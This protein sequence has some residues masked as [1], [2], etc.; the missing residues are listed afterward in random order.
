[1]V[2]PAGSSVIAP[3]ASEASLSD[4]G[5]QL[6]PPFVEC[7]TPPPAAPNQMSSGLTGLTAMAEALPLTRSPEKNPVM[8]A[9]PIGNQLMPSITAFSALAF[10]IRPGPVAALTRAW[11]II[12]LIASKALVR[13]PSGM[14]LG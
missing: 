14:P 9:G 11:L 13:A 1:T 12:S 3:I 2:Q 4:M 10:P 8:G 7:Q 5:A 6:T